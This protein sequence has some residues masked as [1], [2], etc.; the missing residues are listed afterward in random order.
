MLITSEICESAGMESSKAMLEKIP[1][2]VDGNISEPD[3]PLL[4]G[5]TKLLKPKKVVEIGV[6]SGWSGCLFVDT[7]IQN[8]LP[9]EYIGI[10]LSPR[11][12]LDTSKETGAA[13]TELF[14][15]TAINKKMLFG[16]SA[17]DCLEAIG[18]DIDLAFIDG[19]HRH[20][21]AILDLLSLLPSLNPCSYVLLHDINLS[22][23]ERH[24]QLNRGPKYLFECWPYEKIHS[25]QYLPMI[26]AVKIPTLIDEGFLTLLLN[27]VYTPWEK[28]VEYPLLE[29]IASSLG[30]A[31]GEVWEQKFLSAFNSM[32]RIVEANYQ[33]SQSSTFI[34]K[35]INTTKLNSDEASRLDLLKSA[36]AC[37]P[38]SS[39]LYH[40]I[41]VLQLKLG[42][43]DHALTSAILAVEAESNNPH[44]LSFL[45]SLYTARGELELAEQL[46]K[47]AISIKDDF[48]VFHYRLS[49]VYNKTNRQ[50]EALSSLNTASQLEPGNVNYQKL[51]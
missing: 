3:Q 51:K 15:D 13:I 14:P 2:W 21:F 43:M 27:T 20:P 40:N 6:A 9:A 30:N 4:I 39:Q 42:E 8:S 31:Y 5:L 48:A 17:I 35:L 7:L 18:G 22:T 37:F 32:N 1:A 33:D 41:S 28:K 10:D 36:A 16:Q 34:R 23:F 19:D 50:S 38:P 24:K 12:Y 44:Y 45:G 47:Q 26:G 29:K 46:L 49:D 25:S 11:Y